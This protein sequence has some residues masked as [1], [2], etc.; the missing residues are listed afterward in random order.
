MNL[1]I[2]LLL[3]IVIVAI[4]VVSII[5]GVRR[6][7]VKSL[8]GI[9]GHAIALVLALIFSVQLGTYL[10]DNYIFKPM[11]DWVVNQLTSDP[12]SEKT[13]ISDVDLDG[14]FD[15]LPSFFTET[16]SY[17]G[18]DVDELAKQYDTFKAEGKEQAKSS[19]IELMV[20][21]LS[22]IVSRVIAFVIIY[23]LALIAV[24]ILW[25]LSDLIA[26]IPV[27]RTFNQAGGGLFGA[28][29][30][31]ILVFIFVS[32]AHLTSPYVL[33]DKPIAERKEIYNGTYIYSRVCE[34]NPLT[35]VFGEWF[36]TPD[37]TPSDGAELQETDG[38]PTL[39][40]GAEQ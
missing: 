23:V 35:G 38:Q 16:F 3:D 24:R 33:K 37:E 8:V 4:F 14:L 27:V 36:N 20:K 1:V 17:L 26:K 15:R 21:P 19:I 28:V 29:A 11:N 31:V 5:I 12:E 22:S 13:P 32:I 9:F 6:G 39:S 25:H 30:G 34:V 10:N 18:L 7:L 2:S 40:D